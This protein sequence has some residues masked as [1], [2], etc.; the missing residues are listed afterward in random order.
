MNEAAKQRLVGG[1]TLFLVGVIFIPL[2]LDGPPPGRFEQARDVA[3]AK[4]EQDDVVTFKP[5]PPPA[6]VSV[7]SAGQNEVAKPV[8]PEQPAA[9]QAAPAKS[10]KPTASTG[11]WIVQVGSFGSK[12][13][14]AGLVSKLR[15]KGFEARM[16]TLSGSKGPIYRVSVG[17]LSSRQQA[18]K[19]RDRIK[20]LFGTAGLVRKRG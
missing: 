7:A 10:P 9:R 20:S 12:A 15:N 16:D 4:S 11:D 17:P 18:V 2:I 14:A 3:T 5:P 13:N 8:K 19:A 1:L 6:K